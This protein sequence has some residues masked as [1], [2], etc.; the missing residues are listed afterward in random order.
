MYSS[1]KVSLTRNTALYAEKVAMTLAKIGRDTN[2]YHWSI[3]YL[4]LFFRANERLASMQKSREAE[5]TKLQ[6]MLRK[7]DMKVAALE[8]TVEEMA[9]DNRDLTQICDELLIAKYGN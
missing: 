9:R 1:K 6:A 5:V 3:C 2:I 4:I 7:A 8:R